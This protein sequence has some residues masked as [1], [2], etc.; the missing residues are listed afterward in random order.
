MKKIISLLLAV[1]MLLSL[2][3][4][5]SISANAEAGVSFS[6][7][8]ESY[9]VGESVWLTITG[10]DLDSKSWVGLYAPGEPTD[11]SVT[12][13]AWQYMSSIN[14]TAV[15]YRND[16][17]GALDW[18]NNRS[19]WY[20]F[21]A[22]TYTVAVYADG[23]YTVLD[24]TT[25][26]I[27][28]PAVTPTVSFSFDK[29]SYEIG[30]A[31]AVTIEAANVPS[32]S[33][34]G[35]Y[36]PGGGSTSYG[37][38][39]L[40]GTFTKTINL[41]P[42]NDELDTWNQTAPFYAGTWS[43]GLYDGANQLIGSAASFTVN[44]GEITA[45]YELSMSKEVAEG[46]DVIYYNCQNEDPTFTINAE[47]YGDKDWIAIHCADETPGGSLPS[48]KYAYISD[49]NGQAIN[50]RTFEG[51]IDSPTRIGHKDLP[52]TDY[53]IYVCLNDGYAVATSISFKVR[54]HKS[55]TLPAVEPTCEESGLTKGSKCE[56]CDTVITEQ[57]T[58]P[59][60]GH[61]WG[62]W[63]LTTKPECEKAGEETRVCA[64]NEAHV[65]KRPVDALEH[66][67]Q[68]TEVVNP[69]CTEQ[70]YTVY[71]CSNCGTSYKADYVDALNHNP[72]V[73]EKGFAPTCKTAG[74]TDLI[75]CSRCEEVLQEQTPIKP[76]EHNWGEWTV[77]KE[78]TCGETG[79]ETRVCA[80]DKN[81][82]ETREIEATGEHN[83]GLVVTSTAT[84]ERTGTV[85][86]RC[87]VCGV[88]KGEFETPI[89]VP[90]IEKATLSKTSFVYD[91]TAKK[92]TVVV[93]DEAGNEIASKY[94]TVKYENN[95]K[96]G[97]A[98]AIITFSDRYEGTITLNFSIVL[99]KPTLKVSKVSQAAVALKWNKVA[100]AKYYRVY[101]YNTKTGKYTTV[102][103]STT[104]TSCT[105]KKLA[106]GTT[107]Y[108]LVR[109]Y[110]LNKAGNEVLSPYTKADNVKAITLC[111][112]PTVKAAVKGKTV[113]LKWAKVTGAKF[114]RVYKYNTKTKK[115]TTLLKSTT[116]LTASF[117][118]QPKGNNYYLVRAFNAKSEGSVYTTKNLVKA[119]VKK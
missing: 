104:A 20:G 32:G 21:P 81:H 76:T 80:N 14:G 37:W 5:L 82:K 119:V 67:Y 64:R 3:S 66:N 106:A 50:I 110:F 52:A 109:A 10:T 30:D 9:E 6:F 28:P 51:W 65:E 85:E 75:I 112:A 84:T 26:T 59:A 35:V 105:V 58:I 97:T 68:V 63:T 7:D 69:T 62:E 38:A 12:S 92:P 53:T 56:L 93:K 91:N 17:A 90:K 95:T 118:S 70:G 96:V 107:Y 29:E 43:V 39:M 48:I 100:G 46:E 94:Y 108:Y 86:N 77:T 60:L 18:T 4:G 61:D 27:N 19:E 78:A 83:Y 73:A 41:V 79:I 36:A 44:P 8:K 23:G 74:L 101:A 11:G 13:I 98:K 113:T 34:L 33:W 57:Q 102:V 103:K 71:T 25:F 45:T 111:K 89:I 88:R 15:D 1:T 24:S 40:D 31:V 99:A 87:L 49:I 115:Y 16:A 2:F 54:D 72:V 47:N 116:K 55:E 114:Y 117:K 42:G 22:G